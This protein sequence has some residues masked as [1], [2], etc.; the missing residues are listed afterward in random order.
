MEE[1]PFVDV[2]EHQQQNLCVICVLGT[3]GRKIVHFEL[4]AAWPRSME[5][6][7]P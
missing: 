3:D 4:Q 2:D 6:N 7:M 1:L 5:P